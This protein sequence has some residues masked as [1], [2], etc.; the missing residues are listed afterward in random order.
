MTQMTE[1]VNKDR[2]QN[3]DTHNPRVQCRGKTEQDKHTKLKTA[4]M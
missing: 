3:N 1:L 4:Y 2:H